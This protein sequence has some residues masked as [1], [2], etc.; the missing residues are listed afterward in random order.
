MY[1]FD[2]TEIEILWALRVTTSRPGAIAALEQ[3][4][5]QTKDPLMVEAVQGLLPKLRRMTDK[6]FATADK[7]R[8]GWE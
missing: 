6:E 5:S 8:P 1:T 7:Q 4:L 3:T 2:Y